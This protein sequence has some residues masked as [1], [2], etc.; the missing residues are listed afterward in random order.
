[1]LDGLLITV[2]IITSNQLQDEHILIEIVNQKPEKEAYHFKRSKNET[3]T[4]LTPKITKH[5]LLIAGG[6]QIL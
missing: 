2:K 1:M 4:Y 5:T 6:L 3:I